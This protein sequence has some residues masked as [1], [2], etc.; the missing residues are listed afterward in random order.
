[1]IRLRR[2]I[3]RGLANRWLRV[4]L[5]ILIAGLLAL[6]VFHG[7]AEAAADDAALVCLAVIVL[8]FLVVVPHVRIRAGRLI[9][10]RAG[11]APPPGATALTKPGP[12]VSTISIPLRR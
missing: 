2:A 3:D 6:V 7:T 8:V 9:G 4:F 5:V 12:G 1:V 11:R 10:P